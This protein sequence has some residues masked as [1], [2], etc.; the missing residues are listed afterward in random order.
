MRYKIGELYWNKVYEPIDDFIINTHN[1][2][3]DSKFWH[4]SLL[5]VSMVFYSISY[6]ILWICN[7]SM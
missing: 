4:Y 5:C 7:M 6:F 1:R 2:K 3:L